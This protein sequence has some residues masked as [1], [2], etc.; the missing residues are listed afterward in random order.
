MPDQHLAVGLVAGA[1]ADG[2]DLQLL[3]DLRGHVAGDHLHEDR[4]GTG[5]L[6]GVGVCEHP[7]G[8]IATALDAIATQG[9]LRTAG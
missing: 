7:L 5:L 2:G 9:V 8:R 6:D 1:D 4:E 3:G